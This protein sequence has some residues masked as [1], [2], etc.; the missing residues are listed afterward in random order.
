LGLKKFLNAALNEK[1]LAS[2][3]SVVNLAF[4]G[5]VTEWQKEENNFS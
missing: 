2:T 1:R 5:S 4:A 3:L